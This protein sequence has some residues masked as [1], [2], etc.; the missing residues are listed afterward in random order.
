M[1]GAVPHACEGFASTSKNEQQNS[2]EMLESNVEFL[3]NDP[4]FEL[5]KTS[6]TDSQDFNETARSAMIDPEEEVEMQ[7]CCSETTNTNASEVSQLFPD[8]S[9]SCENEANIAQLHRSEN[10]SFATIQLQSACQY[11]PDNDLVNDTQPLEATIRLGSV[12][13][14]VPGEH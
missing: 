3:Y 8:E 1:T 10:L 12:G 5:W 7:V 14:L 13:Q 9:K 11:M 2:S 6:V 4:D